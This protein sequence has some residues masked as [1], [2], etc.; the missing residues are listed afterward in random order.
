VSVSVSVDACH[1]FA[2]RIES[3]DLDSDWSWEDICLVCAVSDITNG[4]TAYSRM[5][6][7]VRVCVCVLC[8]VCVCV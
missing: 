4:E 7:C 6:M 8:C 2:R 1:F 3:R 5:C